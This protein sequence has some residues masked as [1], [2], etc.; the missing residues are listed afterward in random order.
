MEG[1]KAQTKATAKVRSAAE[2]VTRQSNGKAH[3]AGLVGGLMHD[4]TNGAAHPAQIPPAA[5]AA[6]AIHAL[7]GSNNWTSLSRPAPIEIRNAISGW[8]DAACA[9]MRFATCAQ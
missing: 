4:T 6:T 9:V 1:A 2:R 5:E 7:S 3:G 8:R